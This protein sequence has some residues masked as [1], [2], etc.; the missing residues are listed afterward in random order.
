MARKVGQVIARDNSE[1]AHFVFVLAAI[2]N[3]TNRRP[4]PT[5]LFE[6]SK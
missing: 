5:H 3:P 2:L 4:V 1:M 6:V